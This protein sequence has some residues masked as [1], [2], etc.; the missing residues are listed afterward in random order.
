[1]N[2]SQHQPPPTIQL[3]RS[4][5]E[6]FSHNG[7]IP[8]SSNLNQFSFDNYLLVD[9]GHPSSGPANSF[10]QLNLGSNDPNLFFRSTPVS[11]KMS[12][13][14]PVNPN[15]GNGNGNNLGPPQQ[16]PSFNS[17]AAANQGAFN[18]YFPPISQN[19]FNSLIPPSFSSQMRQ[20]IFS[21]P[22]SPSA[23]PESYF[24]FNP[25]TTNANNLQYLVPVKEEDDMEPLPPPAQM[26]N[27]KVIDLN[28]KFLFI[29]SFTYSFTYDLDSFYI[30]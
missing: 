2:F 29:Y 28:S 20:E 4:E 9:Q 14:N 26:A 13:I 25:G 16:L 30:F 7:Q 27:N 17:N 3:D 5:D 11:P 1:M 12:F 21:A 19:Q 8:Q 18:P 6:Q 22:V 15:G 24:N 10:S 23:L